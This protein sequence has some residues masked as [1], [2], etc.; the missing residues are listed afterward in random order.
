VYEFALALSVIC[1]LAVAIFYLRSP[2]ASVFHPFTF[3]L[4][5][6]GFIFVFRPILAYIYDFKAIYYF[7][8]FTPSPS[9][10]LTVILASNVGF[11]VFAYFCLSFGWAQMRFKQDTVSLAERARLSRTFIAVIAICAPIGAYSLYTVWNFATSGTG[12]AGM[13]V[14]QGTG[15]AI[16]TTGNGYLV[17][18]QLM[19]ATLC[20]VIAWL[21]RFRL[22]SLVPL[23]TFALFRAGTGGRMPFVL[24]LVALALI[25]FYE[26]RER[27][28]GGKA[29]LGLAL[30]GGLF[31][32]VGQDRG[33]SIRRVL[34]SDQNA[35]YRV[36]GGYS[37]E[38]R[39]LEGMDFGNLEF[40]EYLVY[41][42]PQRTG[43]Y[44]YFLDNLQVFTE[45]IPRVLWPGKPVGAPFNQIF[46]FDYGRPMGMTRSL[47]GEGW[48]GWGW[49]GVVVVCGVWGAALG[50]I[51]KRFANSPQNTLITAAYVMFLP[52]LITGFRDGMIVTILR[53][54][55]F[56]QAPIVLWAILARL[57][58]IPTAS[59]VRA[60][61]RGGPRDWRGAEATGP[62][63]ARRNSSLA[64][65]PRRLR[66]RKPEP[67]AD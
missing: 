38:V 4:A 15:T 37:R 60:V 65:R 44:S 3:Y 41:A 51:Y 49:F 58:G 26:R 33:Q 48:F 22:I 61:L 10:K 13:I 34:D 67:A 40:F 63:L 23:A 25:W 35:T 52:T 42:I 18:S 39:P 47:P 8:K 21:F 30:V 5:F 32:A 16:N 20:V 50:A 66:R 7:F 11:L 62:V 64:A 57:Q 1:F 46:L 28:P 19:L 54:S 36:Y 29:L 55:L 2:V 14:D 12:Y 53:E 6:H 59:E 9:D 27:M 17:E 24:A 43:T 56:F 31:F 45:P